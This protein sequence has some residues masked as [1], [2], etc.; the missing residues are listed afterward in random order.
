MPKHLRI[1]QQMLHERE[2]VGPTFG[3]Y[4]LWSNNDGAYAPR[5]ASFKTNSGFLPS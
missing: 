4:Y 2:L 1:I 5:N 3:R